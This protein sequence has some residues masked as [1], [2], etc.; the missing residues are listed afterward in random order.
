M[1][2]TGVCTSEAAPLVRADSLGG[3]VKDYDMF[4]LGGVG[5][6]LV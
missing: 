5:D 4:I 1:A 3:R 2:I 6:V